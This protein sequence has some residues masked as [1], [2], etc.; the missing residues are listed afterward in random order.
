MIDY[1]A[2]VLAYVAIMDAN[3]FVPVTDD[4]IEFYTNIG[5]FQG[6][7]GENGIAEGYDYTFAFAYVE[8]AQVD[9]EIKDNGDATANMIAMI[10]LLGGALLVTG[11]VAKKRAF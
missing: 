2:A 5:E 4:I 1:N 8:T 7:Y 9:E 6:W 3:G 11:F 10:V